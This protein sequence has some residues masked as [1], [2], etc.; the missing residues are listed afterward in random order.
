MDRRTD[1]RNEERKEGGRGVEKQIGT[2]EL[3]RK[4]GET[5]SRGKAAVKGK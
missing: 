1:R 3:G 5:K 4:Q 2:I